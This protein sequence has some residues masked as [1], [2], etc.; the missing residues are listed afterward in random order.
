VKDL[1]LRL[2]AP[3]DILSACRKL[4]SN[5]T[6]PLHT[7]LIANIVINM[8][9]D[10]GAEALGNVPHPSADFRNLPHASED[11]R[12]VPQDS[13]GFGNVPN[14]SATF[15]I[16]PKAAAKTEQHTLTVREVARLFESHGVSRT[17]RSITNWCQPNRQGIARLDAFFDENEGR[18]YITPQSV[19]LAIEEEKSRNAGA[20]NATE[21]K[22]AG[23]PK[24]AEDPRADTPPPIVEEGRAKELE[25]QNRD[26]EITNR[27][28]D[29]YIE[30]LES[31][32]EKHVDKMIGMSR[33]V[34]QLETQVMQLGGHASGEESLPGSWER[35][36]RGMNAV[37]RDEEA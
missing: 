23:V 26:L 22:N 36:Q 18:Y 32:R 10:Q 30:K 6:V 25:R 14:D 8:M 29:A 34:G 4:C 9:N 1:S 35:T 19:S 3:N 17:E 7:V 13:A 31:E 24:P 11:F 27:M 15:R 37:C 20:Q 16:L 28:K 21:I 5:R 33:Y 2:V 12:N